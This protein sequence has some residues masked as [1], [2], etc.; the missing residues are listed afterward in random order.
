VIETRTA[1]LCAA[2][3]AQFLAAAGG[4]GRIVET[5][6]FRVHLWTTPDT[7]YRN[8]AAPIARPPN[9]P[10]AL[11]IAEMREVFRSHRRQP[12]V[13]H[14]AERWP[15]LAP[16]LEREGFAC[17]V[18]LQAMAHDGSILARLPPCPTAP[19]AG[20]LDGSTP[21]PLLHSYLEALYAAFDERRPS[22][23]GLDEAVR[24]QRSLALS[25][26]QIGIVTDEGGRVIAGANL[27][28]IG[29]VVGIAGPVGELSGVWTADGF[30]G[31][32]FAHRLVAGLLRRFFAAG[33]G[34]VWLAA[35]D[36]LASGLYAELGFRPIGRLLRYSRDIA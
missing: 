21:V 9:C 8:V 3:E 24:L 4:A 27:V 2:S 7:F 35:D 32:G 17:A 26:T 34:L 13:E 11:A 5:S 29:P 25:R 20:P 22:A 19:T 28:G 31:R 36:R 16:A 18:R 10:L 23:V 33:G 6:G 14:F 30:R 15:R 12:T 1:R